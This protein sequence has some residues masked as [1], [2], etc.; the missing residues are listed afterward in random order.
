MAPPCV[1]AHISARSSS[2]QTRYSAPAATLVTTSVPSGHHTGPSAKA[3]PVATTSDFMIKI[4]PKVGPLK[5]L[6]FEPLTSDAEQLF[7]DSGRLAQ[8]RYEA[9]LFGCCSTVLRYTPAQ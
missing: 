2:G 3:I 9:L 1:F 4:L 8:G 6:A 7:I 5:P